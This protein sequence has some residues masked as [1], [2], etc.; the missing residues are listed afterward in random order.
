MLSL[1]DVVGWSL[2]LAVGQSLAAAIGQSSR[3]AARQTVEQSNDEAQQFGGI[4]GVAA[5]ATLPNPHGSDLGT[6]SC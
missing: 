6:G 1:A 4:D 3:A 2:A 5:E